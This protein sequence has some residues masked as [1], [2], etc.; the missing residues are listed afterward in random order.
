M[1][2]GVGWNHLHAYDTV[3]YYYSCLYFI[4]ITLMYRI[5]FIILSIAS[6]L[7][8]ELFYYLP[9]VPERQRFILP[10][11]V[12]CVN[13]TYFYICLRPLACVCKNDANLTLY[14]YAVIIC[15][16]NSGNVVCQSSI[17]L[18]VDMAEFFIFSYIVWKMRSAMW[19]SN[20][21]LFWNPC[22]LK[23]VDNLT[24]CIYLTPFENLHLSLW[25]WPYGSFLDN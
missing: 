16:E 21:N 17:F 14:M 20:H 24:L 10:V 8:Q 9:Y 15:S 6:P 7:A 13:T 18:S 5:Q 3:N 4:I 22:C 1:E 2:P 23:Y 12:T 25:Y 11:D 19:I